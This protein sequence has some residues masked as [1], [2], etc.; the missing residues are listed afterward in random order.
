MKKIMTIATITLVIL[1]IFAGCS[2]Q[3]PPSTQNGQ[4]EA[5]DEQLISDI[6]EQFADEAGDV[7]IGETLESEIPTKCPSGT[8]CA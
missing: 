7:D 8:K 4:Q 2:K 6:D 3:T 5:S 1:I